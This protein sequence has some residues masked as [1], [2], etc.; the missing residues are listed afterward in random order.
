MAVTY[1]GL[2]K[3][4]YS[5]DRYL[6]I[7]FLVPIIP[8][9]LRIIFLSLVFQHDTPKSYIAKKQNKKAK[10]VLTGIY[11]EEYVEQQF[12]QIKEDMYD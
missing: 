8:C 11:K 3:T 1:S 5:R 6:N 10:K 4:Y 9:F 12:N 2:Y 7:I